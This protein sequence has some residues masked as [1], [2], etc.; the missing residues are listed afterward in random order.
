MRRIEHLH[1]QGCAS[2]QV[3][4]GEVD[5]FC[6]RPDRGEFE[7]EKRDVDF[8]VD[9]AVIGIGLLKGP[10]EV[11]DARQNVLL[12]EDSGVVLRRPDVV[13]AG[14]IRTHRGQHAGLLAFGKHARTVRV[15]HVVL[16]IVLRSARNGT[17]VTPGV[18]DGVGGVF[19]TV[20]VSAALGRLVA[21]LVAPSVLE[22]GPVP[23]LV[24]Q[25]F[26]VGPH[27]GFGPA[28]SPIGGHDAIVDGGGPFDIPWIE[29]KGRAIAT[30]GRVHHPDVEVHRGVPLDKL[31]QRDVA[32]VVCQVGLDAVD[33]C[34]G[35]AIGV[36]IG[37]PKHHAHIRNQR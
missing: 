29:G 12:E 6:Q 33:A 28:D 22:V 4:C 24:G 27:R 14:H 18:A 20:V 34:R 10:I 37:E 11:D 17:G 19:D 5:P 9:A 2:G 8:T 30:I 23:H 15:V 25:D 36:E 13:A 31:L 35:L 26:V 7:V 21:R 3:A 32:S 1:G 16:D